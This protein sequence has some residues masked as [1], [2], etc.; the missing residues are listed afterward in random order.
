M[1]IIRKDSGEIASQRELKSLLSWCINAERA[2]IMDAEKIVAIIDDETFLD[3]EQG[4]TW[5]A[6]IQYIGGVRYLALQAVRSSIVLP[7]RYD[8]ESF[9]KSDGAATTTRLL[10]LELAGVE[11]DVSF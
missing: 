9:R 11:Y 4:R 1:R 6:A 3:V 2:S 5:R 10:C 8:D 7:K